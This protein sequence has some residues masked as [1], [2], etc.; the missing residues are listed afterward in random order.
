MTAPTIALGYLD[1]AVAAAARLR[2][3]AAADALHDFRVAIRR[4]RVTIRSYV[5]LRDHI[6]KNQRRRLRKLARATNRARDAEVQIAWFNEHVPSFSAKQRAAVSRVRARLRAQRRTGLTR[7]RA[8][9]DGSFARLE[10]K[11]RRRL[12]ALRDE[13]PEGRTTAFGAVA[14]ATL[15]RSAGELDSR[16]QAIARGAATSPRAMHA[17][18][19]AAKRLRYTLEPVA[20]QVL[21]G[22]ELVARLKLL[23]D[24][25][26][27]L[28]DAHELDA[29]LGAD[30]RAGPAVQELLKGEA[31][32][33][34]A[35]LQVDLKESGGFHDQIVAAVG[36]LRPPRSGAP[37]LRNLPARR[38]LGAATRP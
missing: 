33:S 18:R 8:R 23:Q 28:T 37:L 6:P 29:V 35:A 15:V 3:K 36:P 22:A 21:G 14:A 12:I 9:L 27:A 38:S 30:E 5:E 24:R 34:A 11:L 20:D 13:R 26:G 25:F 1:D 32:A 4:L 2:G 16:L 10:H 17:A 31:A 7:I 19:I